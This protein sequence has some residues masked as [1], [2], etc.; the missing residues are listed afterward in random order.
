MSDESR[1]PSALG[2]MKGELDRL[3]RSLSEITS[4]RDAA[5]KELAL[6]AKERDEHKARSTEG[7]SHK[8]K[9]ESLLGEHRTLKHK[10]T[11]DRLARAAGAKDEAIDDLFS[12]AGY[13][14]ESDE[15]D[16]RKLGDLVD[17]MR[18]KRG[19]AFAESKGSS[20]TE[21]PK[22][23]FGS[24]A[25]TRGGRLGSR[26]FVVTRQQLADPKWSLDK[27]NRAAMAAAQ[28]EGRLVFAK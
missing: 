14:A 20:T 28:K 17:A 6:A 13:K 12:L 21:Q 4:E 1:E 10:A 23:Q 16:E 15:A 9:Y 5:R 24:P 18:E 8:Q 19:Y 7:E 26:D 3:T 25:E 11:F 27:A 22:T 2:V